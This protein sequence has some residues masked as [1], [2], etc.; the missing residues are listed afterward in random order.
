MKTRPAVE[1][2]TVYSITDHHGAFTDKPYTNMYHAQ[3]SLVCLKNQQKV[4]IEKLKFQH[5]MP[6]QVQKMIGT[7]QVV[8]LISHA[9]RRYGDQFVFADGSIVPSN[10]IASP[11]YVGVKVKPRVK[12]LTGNPGI[13]KVNE[14]IREAIATTPDEKPARAPRTGIIRK[15]ISKITN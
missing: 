1:G 13:A 4:T 15:V 9:R 12:K 8:T 14:A 7:R 2:E 5:P 11:L 10:T 6:L 3:G